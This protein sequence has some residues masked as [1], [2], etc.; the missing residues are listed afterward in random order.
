MC[1]LRWV[2]SIWAAGES[3]HLQEK[4]PGDGETLLMWVWYLDAMLPLWT[5]PH[6]SGIGWVSDTII[7]SALAAVPFLFCR[8]RYTPVRR[9]AILDSFH[10]KHIGRK[11]LFIWCTMIFIAGVECFLMLH[12]GIW[13]V[14]TNNNVDL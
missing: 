1:V 5:F 4:G 9:K 13:T 14:G 12:F 7:F 8:L 6:L 3:Y 10:C 11:M 2:D